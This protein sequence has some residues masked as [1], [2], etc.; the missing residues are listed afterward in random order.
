LFSAA[1]R[2]EYHGGSTEEISDP[3]GPESNSFREGNRTMEKQQVRVL[4]IV[5]ASPGDVQAERKALPDV[6]DEIN[7][8]VAADRNLR[9]ELSRWETDTYPG[10]HADGP[11]GEIDKIL[12]IDDC[13]LL[14][15]IFWHR[16]GT[17]TMDAASGTEHEFKLARQAWQRSGRPQIMVYFNDKAYSP[18]S[19]EETD[20]WG[21]VLEFKSNFPKEGLWWPYRGSKQLASL[22]R[23]HLTQYVRNLEARPRDSAAL[24]TSEST[25]T[26]PDSTKRT[27]VF[28]SFTKRYNDILVAAHDLDKRVKTQKGPSDEGDAHQIY[29]Q[30][31]SLMYDEIHAYQE[32]LLPKKV[33]VEWM[34]WQMYE[35]T[36]GEFKIGGVSY[37]NGW[38]W[39]LSTPAKH[40][41]YTPIMKKIF[42][43]KDKECV[44]D[45]IE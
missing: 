4:R 32:N 20:Q 30:L 24:S 35:Y 38:Q 6:I 41:E 12:R 31:F 42:A 43:C 45:V 8:G 44:K 40:H 25:T 17:P 7:R 2:Q 28:L 5:V 33:L 19:R 39:W 18:R 22:V 37:D 3:I 9:L 15:G 34:T 26:V 10:F 36:G 1:A 23:N 11:Q 16:F 13:D 27:E 14:I 21:R 29:F